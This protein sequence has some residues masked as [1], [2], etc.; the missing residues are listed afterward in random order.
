MKI[1]IKI[2]E[3]TTRQYVGKISSSICFFEIYVL[4]RRTHEY[5]DWLLSFKKPV[6]IHMPHFANGINFANPD[7][8]DI[9][10]ESLEYSIKLADY[11]G[12]EK[13]IFHPELIENGSRNDSIDSAVKFFKQNYD[14]RLLV[15]NM[16]FSS[17]GHEHLGG[18]FNEIADI[19]DHTGV[20]FC[21]DFAHAAE[22]AKK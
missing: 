8:K 5:L 22:Y 14:P 10:L 1:G 17:D 13:I 11:L 21:L 4:P 19:I 2:S 6:V 15:E 12:S 7:R 16:P 3:Q 18:S 20:N 9:N